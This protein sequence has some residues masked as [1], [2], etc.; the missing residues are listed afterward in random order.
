MAV[1]RKK[2]FNAKVV[3]V[4]I[5]DDKLALAKVSGADIVIN[6]KDTPNSAEKIQELT[7]G[8]HGAVVTAV[9]KSCFQSS[10]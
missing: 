9:S 5:N 2:V 3:A 4:D 1:S 8:C 10:R 7:G 6:A